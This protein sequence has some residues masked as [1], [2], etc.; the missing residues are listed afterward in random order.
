[1]KKL[2]TMIIYILVALSI[3]VTAFI[4]LSPQF[5]TNPS[6][7]QKQLYANYSNYENGEFQNV[8]EFILMTED[9][10]MS[11]FFRNDS[12]RVPNKDL[13]H[14]KI[15]LESFINTEEHKIKVSW[16]GHSAFILNIGGYILLLDPMLGQY[17]APFPLPSLKRYSS[18]IAFSIDDIDSIDAV[19]L[20]HDHYDHLDYSTIRQIKN[21]V[22]TFFVPYGLGNH[23]KGWG[24]NQESIIELYWGESS[25]FNGIEFVCLPA[26]H[27]SGRGPLNRNST[28]WCSWAIKSE[29]GKIYFSGDSGYGNH[30]KTIG[31]MHGPFDL[32]FIDCGQYNVAWKYSHMIPEEAVKA[33]KDLVSNYFMPIH[34]GAFTL[35]THPWE[36][37]VIRAINHAKKTNQ[38]II[39]PKL[40]QIILLHDDMDNKII[41]WWNSY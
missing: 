7:D 5:G 39:A 11:E 30:F 25:N 23:L 32:S 17:A 22:K 8:E 2:F 18:D 19:I 26:R 3:S 28:L 35:S 13:I 36:E 12:N 20:S 40:G 1:M 6:K 10:P 31:E 21:K 14:E 38:K 41:D 16:L 33:S 4:N 37:P 9:M 29:Y 27:F 15:D 24:V 34:W